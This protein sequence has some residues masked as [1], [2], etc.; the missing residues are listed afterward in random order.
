MR[1]IGYVRVSTDKQAERGCSLEAC[2]S[3]GAANDFKLHQGSPGGF[4]S[5]FALNFNYKEARNNF[6]VADIPDVRQTRLVKKPAILASKAPVGSLLCGSREYIRKAHRARK[7]L[8]GGMRQAGVLAAAG[9]VA[10]DKMVSRLG[11]DH[12]RAR[13]LAQGLRAIPGLRLDPGTPATNMVFFDLAPE[14]RHG[15]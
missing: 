15:D 7:M 13:E 14:V 3:P 2:H 5:Q 11:E 6:L 1:A 9:I 4:Y 10:L 8:G 12:E